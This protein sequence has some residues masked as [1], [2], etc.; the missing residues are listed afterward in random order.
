MANKVRKEK[1]IPQRM[2]IVCRQSK[3]KKD[4]IRI[5][6]NKE[7]GLV[8]DETGKKNGRGAY[9]CKSLECIENAKKRKS[10]ERAFKTEVSDDLYEEIRSYVEK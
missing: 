10:L 8:I 5:V 3:D 4:L 9:I 2:C 1:K 6:N 7:E